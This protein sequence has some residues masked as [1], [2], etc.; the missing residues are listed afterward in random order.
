M[1][2]EVSHH[3]KKIEVETDRQKL[4]NWY[5]NGHDKKMPEI[6]VAALKRAIRLKASGFKP[7]DS[8]EDAV[9]HA[10]AGYEVALSINNSTRRVAANRTRNLLK[11]LGAQG[12]LEF[13]V[14]ES[15]ETFG[16]RLLT[17][18]QLAEFTFENVIINFPDRFTKDQVEEANR[19]R[20]EIL[21]NR[22]DNFIYP[23]I[24]RNL[25]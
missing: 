6:M 21:K 13:L 12:A 2:S 3:I 7:V 11:R 19:R 20:D 1:A 18:M 4:F 16:L 23:R 14:E 15:R 24:K 9:Y 5:R 8:F 10:L 22:P 25:F 17:S